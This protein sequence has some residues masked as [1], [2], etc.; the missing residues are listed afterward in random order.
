VLH[1]RIAKQ[2][3]AQTGLVPLE[4]F[5]MLNEG[6]W[7]T[8]DLEH[9]DENYVVGYPNNDYFYVVCDIG[10]DG[11]QAD[12]KSKEIMTSIKKFLDNPPAIH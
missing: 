1:I 8:N 12:R 5:I 7:V 4:A 9:F 6:C 2:V 11:V 10:D 3:Y